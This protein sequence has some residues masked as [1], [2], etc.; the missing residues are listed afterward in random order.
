MTKQNL[1]FNLFVGNCRTVLHGSKSQRIV[2][3]ETLD[4]EKPKKLAE[5]KEIYYE[6]VWGT[7]ADTTSGNE[8]AGTFSKGK[9]LVAKEKALSKKSA[10]KLR[11]K[12][13][14]KAREVE[15]TEK[16]RSAR[17]INRNVHGVR[18]I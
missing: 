18:S 7:E 11:Q 16:G 6:T 4:D 14:K 17:Q 15:G 13:V 1:K 8:R 12:F 9:N 5:K 3:L 10:S 2:R